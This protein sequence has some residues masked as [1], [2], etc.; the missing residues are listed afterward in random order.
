[1]QEMEMIESGGQASRM[2]QEFSTQGFRELDQLAGLGSMA[3]H[4]PVD[5]TSSN[6]RQSAVDKTT[7]DGAQAT[8]SASTVR[9]RRSARRCRIC[10]K[11]RILGYKTRRVYHKHYS[12]KRIAKKAARAG[13]EKSFNCPSCKRVHSQDTTTKRLKIC[14]TSSVLSEHWL[15]S[16]DENSGD[17]IHINWIC[18]P[19]AT[20]NQL[21]TAWEVEYFNEKRPMDIMLIGGIN[22]IIRGSSGPSIVNAFRHFVNLVD[23]QG[24]KYHPEEPNTCVIGPLYYPPKLCW[25]EDDGQVPPS[26]Q[27]HLRNMRWL[28]QQIENINR[29]SGLKAPNFPTMG[30]RKVTK[31]GRGR[32][33]HRFEH[34]REANRSDMLHLRDDQRTKMARQVAR[35]FAHNTSN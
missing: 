27:N 6:Q 22:N 17:A 28:N 12:S 24:E 15:S 1:M 26:F 9:Q 23:Y 10:S 30:V 16:N 7:S 18:I 33:R 19:G 21:T 20:I 13:G 14:I 29:E 25:F 5:N 34:W 11:K 4:S 31:Y 35:Y 32:T 2:E 3:I 8:A